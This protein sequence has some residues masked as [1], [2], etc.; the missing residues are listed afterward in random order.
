MTSPAPSNDVERAPRRFAPFQD[1]M[2]AAG[3]PSRVIESFRRQYTQLLQ[4]ETGYIPES[5][6]LPLDHLP[7]LEALEKSYASAGEEALGR[8]VVIKLN[9]GLGT[10]MG[11]AG[12]KSLIP[13]KQGLS[14]LDIAVRQILALRRHWNVRLPLVFMDSFH[15]RGATLEALAAYPELVADL[16]LDFLQHRVPK[17]WARDLT[18]VEW[19]EDPEKAWAPPG[20]GDIYLALYTSGMLQQMLDAG[21]EYAFVSN[22]D[23]LCATVDMEILGYMA[24]KEIPFL[25][26]ATRR[27]PADRKGGHLARRA[28]GSLL[29]REIAQC[30]PEEQERFQDIQRYRYFNTNNLWVHLPSL[31]RLLEAHEGILPLPLIRNQK[32][33]DPTRPNT[34]QVYQLETA[35]GHAVGLFPGA[36]ALEVPRRRFRPVKRTDDLLALWSD[37]YVL[38]PDY[39]V[40]L[41]PRRETLDPPLGDPLVRLDEG[42]YRLFR[43]FQARFSHG[44]PSMVW[45]RSLVVEGDVYF[46]Q[47]IVLRGDVHIVHAGPEPLRLPDGAVLEGFCSGTR[48][49]SV[50]ER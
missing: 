45:C 43:E 48:V 25:M 11:M 29:L 1:R 40:V 3:I 37:A 42:H 10:S 34:P 28:D 18:P 8:L 17:I 50:P 16:P 47:A 31:A 9:G 4:G 41:D 27:T 30:P 39:R 38:T 35:M 32:P 22:I 46:G 5:Q 49:G 23:N 33:V 7:C 15:T 21:Y 19:P 24:E 36:Q 26:E 44:A 14:F 13:V 2:Q 12:P 6:A 20:H